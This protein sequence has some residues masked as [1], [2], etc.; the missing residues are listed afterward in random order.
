MNLTQQCANTS[1][2]SDAPCACDYVWINEPQYEELSGKAFC[3][4]DSTFKQFVG[5]R[6]QTKII[7]ITFFYSTFHSHAFSLEFTSENNDSRLSFREFSFTLQDDVYIRYNSFENKNNLYEKL[8]SQVPIKF[9]IGAEYDKRP[10]KLKSHAMKPVQKELVF[11]ID[12]TDYDPVR[13][14]CKETDI[15]D[16]CWYFIVV[17]C[18]ILQTAL[19]ADLAGGENGI[20]FNQVDL[21]CVRNKY[22]Y[23]IRA[24]SKKGINKTGIYFEKLYHLKVILNESSFLS[25][26]EKQELTNNLY[27]LQKKILNILKQ[28]NEFEDDLLNEIPESSFNPEDYMN[29]IRKFSTQRYEKIALKRIKDEIISFEI[30]DSMSTILDDIL[31]YD[32]EDIYLFSRKFI[33]SYDLSPEIIEDVTRTVHENLLNV[34]KNIRDIRNFFI[35]RRYK[36]QNCETKLTESANVGNKN[37]VKTDVAANSAISITKLLNNLKSKIILASK[38]IKDFEE[39]LE[40]LNNEYQ[41]EKDKTTNVEV[42]PEELSIE[43]HQNIIELANIFDR[44]RKVKL[45][46]NKNQRKMK[47]KLTTS[48]PSNP[49]QYRRDLD[50]ACN[51]LIKF[52]ADDFISP[53]PSNLSHDASASAKY[54]RSNELAHDIFSLNRNLLNQRITDDILPALD[55]FSFISQIYEYEY[56]KKNIPKSIHDDIAG[57][58]DLFTVYLNLNKYKEADELCESI[59]KNT[60]DSKMRFPALYMNAFSIEVNKFTEVNEDPFKLINETNKMLS[61][62]NEFKI[63]KR[64]DN[65]P[66]HDICGVTNGRK[67]LIELGEKGTVS[68]KN[69]S[70]NQ[71]IHHFRNKGNVSTAYNHCTLELITCPYCIITV[72]FSYM[73]LT[74]QCANTSSFSDAPCAC[75]YV[76][77]NEPQYEELS[78]KAFCGVDSTFKQFVGFRSQTKIITITFFY[79]TFHSHA[80]SLEFTSERNRQFLKGSLS[81]IL[82]LNQSVSGYIASPYFPALYARDLTAEYV[83]SCEVNL[84]S[85]CRIRLIFTDFQ[86]GSLSFMEFYNWNGDRL[87]ITTGSNFRPPVILSSGPSL[88]IIFH[89]NSGMG[90]G[91]KAA[92]TFI[93]SKTYNDISV[94]PN[95]NCGGFVENLGGAITMMNM[96]E[97][98]IQAFDC[99]WLIR[100]PKNYMIKSHLY[101]KVITFQLESVL[102]IREG[103]TSDKPLLETITYPSIENFQSKSQHEHVVLLN[104]GFYVHLRGV[105]SSKTR[106]AIAYTAFGYKD[107]FSGSD[108]FCHNHRCIPAQ[109]SCDSFDHCGD[110]SD[111]PVTCYRDWEV[112]TFDRRWYAH[113][114]NYYFPKIERYP[115]IKTATLVFIVSSLGLIALI[116]SLILLLYRLGNRA[117]QQRELQNQLQ[118]ISDLL[119]SNREENVTLDEPPI[120]EAPPEYDEIIKVGVTEAAHKKQT[121]KRSSRSSSK[122]Q[123]TRSRSLSNRRKSRSKRSPSRNV[124]TLHHH[125]LDSPGP[126]GC[127]PFIQT[128]ISNGPSTSTELIKTLVP[129]SP[130]P[131][132][133]KS[134][135]QFSNNFNQANFNT[136]EIAS[137]TTL[138]GDV[139][140][141]NQMKNQDS[142]GRTFTLIR[143]CRSQDDLIKIQSSNKFM[144]DTNNTELDPNTLHTQNSEMQTTH[145]SVS[146]SNLSNLNI[147]YEREKLCGRTFKDYKAMKSYFENLFARAKHP[148]N[149]YK[150]V[151]CECEGACSCPDDE[152]ISN[153]ENYVSLDND[154]PIRNCRSNNGSVDDR[155]LTKSYLYLSNF[156]LWKSMD[157]NL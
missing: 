3:G 156:K 128:H 101:L 21:N 144:R 17:A 104:I 31:S 29:D 74:Q 149:Q 96:I 153:M 157:N 79:S 110:N 93:S 126:S 127:I 27:S 48:I 58:Y 133:Q 146:D 54:A 82:S 24:K 113:T 63:N 35:H 140:D 116:S 14:C 26:T 108:F 33:L 47:S 150:Q 71:H 123:D 129:D 141:A 62:M 49:S 7:T 109:L 80:F 120:Y 97:E 122:S 46:E 84:S 6:S 143:R 78:G 28:E 70:T 85:N 73:N 100:P 138:S 40:K 114:P 134:I 154:G 19:Q 94:I 44:S 43:T 145:E 64:G 83:I 125:V 132:Y 112:E 13:N 15:C 118:T 38:T 53:L 41:N 30:D 89:A 36:T 39:S 59:F 12:V 147:M 155:I 136:Q 98:G 72:N 23:I 148:R 51:T 60:K 102:T 88:L 20:S 105:F 2:F 9:D 16:E 106:I 152:L 37:S 52:D 10:I 57:K 45:T 5:F 92:Y 87:D 131:T 65:V 115:D 56:H 75:D 117:R 124:A 119:D 61:Q 77:I 99:V 151:T 95:T 68:A 139:R 142:H 4:V 25:D 1:S 55:D 121:K 130:P 11:D 81:N 111:E 67:I 42:Y 22:G 50:D 91:F 76:W 18:Q 69:I 66:Y 32:K 107:C 86:L 137:I 34:L 90:I 103:L 135:E 8:T